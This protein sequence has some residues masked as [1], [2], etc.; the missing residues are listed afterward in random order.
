MT[1][2]LVD[3]AQDVVINEE[4]CSTINGI[5]YAA[6]KEGDEVKVPLKDRIQGHFTIEEV[7][8]PI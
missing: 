4:D 7:V 3:V 6:I 2:K 8:H 5:D 1:R